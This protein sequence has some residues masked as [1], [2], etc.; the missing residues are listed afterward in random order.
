MCSVNEC[1]LCYKPTSTILHK[2]SPWSWVKN[3]WSLQSIPRD[4]D[5]FN[6]HHVKDIYP[7]LGWVPWFWY[8]SLVP[9]KADLQAP[10]CSSK[11]HGHD[12][13]LIPTQDARSGDYALRT[14]SPE[15]CMQPTYV[16]SRNRWS[17]L[18]LVMIIDNCNI[19]IR[20]HE[21]LTTCINIHWDLL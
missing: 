10:A 13:S 15:E 12:L 11:K 21:M 9:I 5:H 4:T 20:V 6:A 18:L 7:S 1:I 16:G 17:I 8:L 14:P 19:N 3:H 2:D